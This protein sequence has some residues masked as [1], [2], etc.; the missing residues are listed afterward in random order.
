MYKRQ[1][2]NIAAIVCD[3]SNNAKKFA[4]DW[5]AR[6]RAATETSVTISAADKVDKDNWLRMFDDELRK[7]IVRVSRDVTPQ[8]VDE[9]S[10]VTWRRSA[11]AGGVTLKATGG[12]HSDVIDACYYAWRK[13]MHWRAHIPR[14]EEPKPTWG[15]PG[16]REYRSKLAME[17]RR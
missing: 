15:Q 11:S 1:K 4:D 2:H 3:F 9:M 14:V 10:K 17:N 12:I 5:S 8:L 6:I 13:S 16:W 7:G